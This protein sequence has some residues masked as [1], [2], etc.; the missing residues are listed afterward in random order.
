MDVGK[1][2]Q[3]LHLFS[4][5]EFQSPYFLLQQQYANPAPILSA[6]KRV[7][8]I[9]V[10]FE[11]VLLLSNTT[12]TVSLTCGGHFHLIRGIWDMSILRSL[13]GGND[14]KPG[15]K[16]S[17]ELGPA[18]CSNHEPFA[19]RL[20]CGLNPAWEGESSDRKSLTWHKHMIQGCSVFIIYYN[21]LVTQETLNET[22]KSEEHG[23]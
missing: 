5:F 18:A 20:S 21:A 19:W 17:S 2:P 9:S 11:L 4:H 12:V 7:L 6:I 16:E 22:I 3:A 10:I 15:G 14:S 1:L 8:G 13:L 23:Q